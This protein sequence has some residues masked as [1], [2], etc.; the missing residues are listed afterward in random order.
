[1]L[2]IKASWMR[3]RSNGSHMHFREFCIATSRALLK[4]RK[5]DK[6]ILET[7]GRNARTKKPKTRPTFLLSHECIHSLAVSAPREDYKSSNKMCL[8]QN[9]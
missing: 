6:L 2:W 7:A 9:I 8:S 4:A 5:T 3:W 1:M